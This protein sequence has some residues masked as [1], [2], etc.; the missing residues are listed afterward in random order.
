MFFLYRVHGVSFFLALLASV[1]IAGLYS[2]LS[3]K[4]IFSTLMRRKARSQVVL[5]AS[6]G[7][8]IATI[9]AMGMLFG[10][11]STLL[12]RRLIDIRVFDVFG[13]SLNMVQITGII[14][15]FIFIGI[16]AYIR[17]KTRFGVIMRAFEDDGEVAELMG[18]PKEKFFLQI[19]FISGM[20]GG[21]WGIAGGFEEGIIPA[22]GLF[23]ILPTIVATVIGG[24]QSFWGGV[25]G[26]FILAAAM[27]LTVVFFGGAWE[28][29]VPFVILIIM[30]LIRPE[31]ILKR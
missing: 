1:L 29:A 26:A 31:G 17:S 12:A 15:C 27:R 13:A 21:L 8:L 4:L 2:L 19:F 11:Q 20:M 6:F 9:A 24:M 5:I 3:Y 25:L 22:A 16:F 14:F 10:N 28:S 23:F 7:L 18:M 30:L